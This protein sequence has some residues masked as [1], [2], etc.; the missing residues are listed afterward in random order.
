MVA[1]EGLMLSEYGKVDTRKAK[2][3]LLHGR[4][5]SADEFSS[6]VTLHADKEQYGSGL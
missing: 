4:A 1:R 2:E 3:R 5:G 6:C